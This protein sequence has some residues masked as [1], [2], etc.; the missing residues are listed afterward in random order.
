MVMAHHLYSLPRLRN[1]NLRHTSSLLVN[2]AGSACNNGMECFH[3]YLRLGLKAHLAP[4][5]ATD[6]YHM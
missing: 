2:A 3:E 6:L 4:K 5:T 1:R